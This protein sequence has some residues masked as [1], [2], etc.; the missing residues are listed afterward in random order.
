MVKTFCESLAA[1]DGSQ[2]QCGME[3][4]LHKPS[5]I[6]LWKMNGRWVLKTPMVELTGVEREALDYAMLER[7]AN[8]TRPM[9]TADEAKEIANVE[10]TS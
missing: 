7:A 2:W 5:G 10:P 1:D 4:A 3:E 6:A 8:L 9:K